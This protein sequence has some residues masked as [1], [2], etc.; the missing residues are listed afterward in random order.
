ME[1]QNAGTFLD[2]SPSGNNG[3]GTSIDNGTGWFNIGAVYNN[4]STDV[5]TVADDNSLDVTTGLTICSWVY[6]DSLDFSPGRP[7]VL[8]STA[9]CVE[10]YVSYALALEETDRAM[11]RVDTGTRIESYS[12]TGSI[13]AN[14]WIHVCGVVYV[15]SNI[16]LYINGSVSGTPTADLSNIDTNGEPI[17]IGKETKCGTAEFFD[18]TIDEVG[19]WNRSLT[20]TEIQEVFE[21][22]SNFYTSSAPSASFVDPTPPNGANNNTNVTINVSCSTNTS[23]VYL[24]MDT[25]NPPT[26]K[27]LD[28][29]S[30]WEYTT[31]YGDNAEYFYMAQCYDANG[32]GDNTSVRN[33]TLDTVSPNINFLSP[34]LNTRKHPYD[35]SNINVTITFNDTNLY[36]YSIN[37]TN[38]SGVGY[39]YNVTNAT[40]TFETFSELIDITSF[41]VGTYTINATATD[42]H[43]ELI[44]K[45]YEVSKVVDKISFETDSK[46]IIEIQALGANSSEYTKLTDRYSYGFTYDMK[47]SDIVKTA[48]GYILKYYLTS[49]KPLIYLP[50]TN[51]RGHFITINEQGRGN[52]I[53]FEAMIPNENI[54][55]NVVNVIKQND[56]FYIVELNIELSTKIIDEKDVISKIT[57]NSIGGLNVKSETRDFTIGATN[58]TL[59]VVELNISDVNITGMTVDFVTLYN[60]SFNISNDNTTVFILNSVNVEKI[61]HPLDTTIYAKLMIDGSSIYEGNIADLSTIGQVKSTGIPIR[62]SLLA[63]GNHTLAYQIRKSI[64]QGD[65][66]VKNN[67]LVLLELESSHGNSVASQY[68]TTQILATGTPYFSG[69]YNWS[70]NKNNFSDTVIFGQFNINK[71]VDTPG[72]ITTAF[73]EKEYPISS[74]S[75]YFQRYLSGVSSVASVLMNYY[76]DFNGNAL[77]SGSK[78]ANY[79]LLLN[80]STTNDYTINGSII[81]FDTF[82]NETN[83]I[84]IKSCGN[85]DTN[86]TNTLTLN[87]GQ[88]LLCNSTFTTVGGNSFLAVLSTSISSTTGL[89]TPKFTINLSDGSGSSAVFERTLTSNDDIGNAYVYHVFEGLSNE[90][91]YTIRFYA[92]VQTGEQL[93]IRDE[94]Y[95]VI[96]TTE[97]SVSEINVNPIAGDIISPVNSTTYYN[98]FSNFTFE[99]FS[100]PDG[101]DTYYN[102]SIVNLTDGSLYHTLATGVQ[103]TSITNYTLNQTGNFSFVVNGYDLF[104]GNDSIVSNFNIDDGIVA[105]QVINNPGTYTLAS[106]IFNG[107]A[108]HTC[109]NINSSNV[110]FDCNGYTISSDTYGYAF[111]VFGGGILGFANDNIIIKN[112]II[113]YTYIP[114]SSSDDDMVVVLSGITNNLTIQNIT[115][116]DGYIFMKQVFNDNIN[117][118]NNNITLLN[119]GFGSESVIYTYA[120]ST[121]VNISNNIIYTED[122]QDIIF[123]ENTTFINISNNN[124]S[125]GVIGIIVDEDSSFVNLLNNNINKT[126]SYGV[127]LGTF[128]TGTDKTLLVESNNIANTLNDCIYNGQLNVMIANNSFN[129]C[130]TSVYNAYGNGTIKNNIITDTREDSIYIGYD[131]QII[132]NNTI[133]NT[134]VSHDAIFSSS[135][136]FLITNNTFRNYLSSTSECIYSPNGNNGSIIN[137]TIIGYRHGV[138]IGDYVNVTNNTINVFYYDIIFYGNYST[139]TNN[140]LYATDFVNARNV[141]FY[142]ATVQYNLIYNNLL[143]TNSSYNILSFNDTVNYFNTTR[144]AGVR[145]Y[146]PAGATEIG[147]NY[148]TNFAGTGYSDTCNDTN[149]DGFCDDNFEIG[150]TYDYLTYSD[151]Y[152]S[153][154]PAIISVQIINQTSYFN[155]TLYATINISDDS[156]LTYTNI[157]WYKNDTLLSTE[158]K[159]NYA[160]GI[161]NTSVVQLNITRDDLV[162]V[163]ITVYDTVGNTNTSGDSITILNTPPTATNILIIPIGFNETTDAICNYTYSDIDGDAETTQSFIWNI[164]G[165]N[166]TGYGQTIGAGNYSQLDN[167]T[168]YV[169]VTDGTNDSGYTKSDTVLV[170]DTTNPLI[171][172][173]NLSATSITDAETITGFGVCTDNGYL[174]G[175]YLEITDPLSA[176]VNYTMTT[177]GDGNYTYT[178]SPGSTG[179]YFARMICSDTAGNINSTSLLPFTVSSSTPVVVGGGGGGGGTII[180]SSGNISFAID[181]E[182]ITYRLSAGSSTTR[183][184]EVI[185]PTSQILSFTLTIDDDNDFVSFPNGLNTYTFTINP[186]VN[187]GSNNR[188]VDY[189]I[190]V[191]DNTPLGNYDFSILVESNGLELTHKVNVEVVDSIFIQIYEALTNELFSLGNICLG[192]KSLSTVNDVEVEV[193][194]EEDSIGLSV[195]PL[196]IIIFFIFISLIVFVIMR[197]RKKKK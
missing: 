39:Y 52:W 9:S 29:S 16:T 139:A 98:S 124:L 45:D 94:S 72:I 76:D 195:T 112:C 178:Y 102:L 89:Q 157:S 127:L 23:T 180:V 110:T 15:G 136:N 120:N 152:D 26:T 77:N 166:F 56:Y 153:Q 174:N 161:F 108:G 162:T 13:V 168:C 20:P 181:P 118:I 109:F 37:I 193:C 71:S 8:K 143:T 84:N 79:T 75:S 128:T 31:S 130:T 115:V 14:S 99:S 85:L 28:N 176:V 43:T 63:K 61:N 104:G 38:S 24:Y 158:Q 135:D 149:L 55:K 187:I 88:T 145:I 117:I 65:V 156:N 21:L 122:N 62:S 95:M 165:T 163:N 196:S 47:S 12:A 17:T 116:I 59:K 183:E 96:E 186:N 7:I 175:V 54:N 114:D 73:S 101:D 69:V 74:R 22:T 132:N 121:S 138:A 123:M 131:G 11:L 182:E 100:S 82:D 133:I 169:N 111:T 144:Q 4:A 140:S 137:N 30:T 80:T 3:I 147:G 19:V 78:I 32:F 184:L 90:T 134:S 129:N 40:S 119:N 33:W 41:P 164:N 92:D 81:S 35:D 107:T 194:S 66:Q 159:I 64:T 83:I 18:G 36:R 49:N 42:S 93:I 60:S 171:T 146:N 58:T 86:T 46:N 103:Y 172:S 177:S 150:T 173:F 6:L 167:L 51:Y 5:I 170:G 189:I 2:L 151:E 25:N 57:F 190:K 192:E 97:L 142:D 148:Y 188:Y 34:E 179:T 106:N 1:D 126:S 87:A 91:E 27:V 48:N 50:N 10:P 191:P 67:K 155:Q 70:L 160:D 113:N 68:N 125:G 44:I 154:S 105:C 53:D 185:N 141:N 197:V